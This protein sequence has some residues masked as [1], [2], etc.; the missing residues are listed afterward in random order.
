MANQFTTPRKRQNLSNGKW[1]VLKPQLPADWRKR[2][3]AISPEY[4]SLEGATLMQN[5]H[6]GR[7]KDES[8]LMLWEKIIDD[9][10]AEKAEKEKR[11]SKVLKRVKINI[12]T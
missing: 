9:Y 6:Q 1:S 12:P 10:V 2:L 3:I 11:V 7:S 4:D 8:I 5:V